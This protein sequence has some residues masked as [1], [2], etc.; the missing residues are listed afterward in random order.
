MLLGTD[1]VIVLI[2]RGIQLEQA[3]N[4]SICLQND[5]STK[6]QSEMLITCGFANKRVQKTQLAQQRDQNG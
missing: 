1:F 3:E 4:V 2:T 6:I 5:S